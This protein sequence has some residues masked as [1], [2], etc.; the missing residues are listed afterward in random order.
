MPEK[1]GASAMEEVKEEEQLLFQ[2]H[3]VSFS[4][5]PKIH[6][7]FQLLFPFLQQGA[8]IFLVP[9]VAQKPLELL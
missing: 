3:S 6:L 8:M 9:E 1:P 5:V 2:P 4:I 7:L